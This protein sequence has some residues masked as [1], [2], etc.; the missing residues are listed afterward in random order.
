MKRQ[1]KAGKPY[2]E[3]VMVFVFSRW[4]KKQSMETTLGSSTLSV[5][6][7]LSDETTHF[8]FFSVSR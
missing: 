7:G 1:A 6:K 8:T 2:N 4:E 3:P 5:K